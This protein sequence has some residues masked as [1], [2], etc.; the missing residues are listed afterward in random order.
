MG[1]DNIMPDQDHHKFTEGHDTG[2]QAHHGTHVGGK[3]NSAYLRDAQ[4]KSLSK[5]SNSGMAV[6]MDIGEEN[7]IHPSHK[8]EGGQRLALLALAK[9]YGFKGFG[10]ESPAYDTLV[11]N[12]SIV[13]VK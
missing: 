6:V 3:F 10:F 8:K 5:I 11:I 12:G 1:K 9:T 2:H 7:N 4:R 13:E